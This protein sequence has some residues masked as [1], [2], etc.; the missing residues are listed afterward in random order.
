MWVKICGCR[1][2]AGV[3]A[4]VEAGA[5]A[6]GFVLVPS[7]RRA[8]D[9]RGLRDL[10]RCV[11]AGVQRVGV[12]VSPSKHAALAAV[13]AGAD[14]LQVIGR[15]PRGIERLGFRIMRTV[16]LPDAGL[17]RG[18]LPRGDWLHLDRRLGSQMGGTGLVANLAAARSIARRHEVVLAG[19]LTPENV[20]AVIQD[21]RPFGV[22]VASGVESG[23][24]QD[25]QRIARFVRAAKEAMA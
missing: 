25:P 7:S 14:M 20:S 13:D 18:P 1:T 5:D 17:P 3:E 22:D 6:V 16:H 9:L 21:V 19:G 12:L 4:A 10:S 2:A 23:G 24:E 8:V 11:P 15:L